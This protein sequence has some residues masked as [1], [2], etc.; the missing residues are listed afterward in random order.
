MDIEQGLLVSKT[1]M[2]YLHVVKRPKKWTG[3]I[4]GYWKK[5]DT[6]RTALISMWN[7]QFESP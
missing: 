7:Q 2:A 6:T 3:Q 4:L 5:R 1:D